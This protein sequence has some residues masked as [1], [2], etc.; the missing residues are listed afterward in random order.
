MEG[1]PQRSGAAD[2]DFTFT[3]KIEQVERL[4]VDTNKNCWIV[5]HARHNNDVHP[6]RRLDPA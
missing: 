2:T 1:C 4:T 5:A 3:L 6:S